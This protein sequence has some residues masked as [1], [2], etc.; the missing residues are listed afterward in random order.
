ME[1]IVLNCNQKEFFSD[2]EKNHFYSFYAALNTK[3]YTQTGERVNQQLSTTPHDAMYDMISS[4]LFIVFGID[5]STVMQKRN[6]NNSST[7]NNSSS[8]DHPHNKNTSF[9]LESYYM[10]H[11]EVFVTSRKDRALR[12]SQSMTSLGTA[13]RRS[14][15][16]RAHGSMSEEGGISKQRPVLQLES[17]SLSDVLIA[18][19][20]LY[21]IVRRIDVYHKTADQKHHLHDDTNAQ[22]LEEVM[23]R[24]ILSY[25]HN[26]SSGHHHHHAHAPQEAQ[27]RRRTLVAKQPLSHFVFESLKARQ[28]QEE[29]ADGGSRESPQLALNEEHV[30]AIRDQ[31]RAALSCVRENSYAAPPPTSATH[32][33]KHAS[34]AS[35]RHAHK[36]APTPQH[37][38]YS[39][40]LVELLF[41]RHTV[42][43]NESSPLL[44]LS[45]PALLAR[46]R[47]ENY[48]YYTMQRDERDAA[49]K[50]AQRS[51]ARSRCGSGIHPSSNAPMFE[52]SSHSNKWLSYGEDILPLLLSASLQHANPQDSENSSNQKGRSRILKEIE[53]INEIENTNLAYTNRHRSSGGSSFAI[54]QSIEKLKVNSISC[55]V[56]KKNQFVII[57]N[58]NGG[59]SIWAPYTAAKIISFNNYNSY[60]LLYQQFHYMSGAANA[61][62]AAAATNA[63]EA[64]TD[65]AQDDAGVRNTTETNKKNRKKINSNEISLFFHQILKIGETI[66]KKYLTCYLKHKENAKRKYVES[67]GSKPAAA[68]R[69][70]AADAAAPAAKDGGSSFAHRMS[71]II[72]AD[73][74]KNYEDEKAF[75]LLQKAY[76]QEVEGEEGAAPGTSSQGE[77]PGSRRKDAAG[78]RAVEDDVTDDRNA[79]LLPHTSAYHYYYYMRACERLTDDRSSL[80][81]AASPETIFALRR[82]FAHVAAVVDYYRETYQTDRRPDGAAGSCCEAYFDSINASNTCA[83]GG[84]G[85]TSGDGDSFVLEDYFF[86]LFNRHELS[87]VEECVPDVYFTAV[88]VA[89][90]ALLHRLL[91]FFN[92]GDVAAAG[93]GSTTGASGG[94]P[95]AIL[96]EFEPLLR[97]Q[98]ATGSPSRHAP[99][100]ANRRLLFNYKNYHLVAR[101]TTY[102]YHQLDGGEVRRAVREAGAQAAAEDQQRQKR[103]EAL[104]RLR[105]LSNRS[106]VEGVELNT[107][108]EDPKDESVASL[109]STDFSDAM[110]LLMQPRKGHDRAL[111]RLQL[112]QQCSVG[113]NDEQFFYIAYFYHFRNYR[114]WLPATV[115]RDADGAGSPRGLVGAAETLLPPA[116][117]VS[118]RSS[119]ACGLNYTVH[120]F[121]GFNSR[122]EEKANTNILNAIFNLA[123]TTTVASSNNSSSGNPDKHVDRI[124]APLTPSMNL[125]PTTLSSTYNNS[126]TSTANTHAYNVSALNS[127]DPTAINPWLLQFTML[128]PHFAYR[129]TAQS[130]VHKVEPGAASM[131]LPANEGIW[132]GP[133]AKPTTTQTPPPRAETA[134]PEAVDALAASNTGKNAAT[135]SPLLSTSSLSLAFVLTTTA[136]NNA[137]NALMNC[138]SASAVTPNASPPPMLALNTA[139]TAA[140][141]LHASRRNSDTNV[142]Y[143]TEPALAASPCYSEVGTH[144][145]EDVAKREDGNGSLPSSS[146]SSG[147]VALFNETLNNANTIYHMDRAGRSSSHITDSHSTM[148][149]NADLRTN[150]TE[151][152]LFLLSGQP[153]RK[154]FALRGTGTLPRP[155]PESPSPPPA[156]GRGAAHT[157]T[158]PR[159]RAVSASK[160]LF[161]PMHPTTS[162]TRLSGILNGSQRRAMSSTA[163]L[164]LAPTTAGGGSGVRPSSSRA[165][166]FGPSIGSR[167]ATASVR[168]S[169]AATTVAAPASLARRQEEQLVRLL[170][171]DRQV[172]QESGMSAV[173]GLGSKPGSGRPLDR[174]R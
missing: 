69:V 129:L 155:R 33:G 158:L 118:K 135:T 25:Q 50:E 169:V 173:P 127:L 14:L 156:A 140:T 115:K 124:P 99:P 93:G 55:N 29:D 36:S 35:L 144:V 174:T 153:K 162:S 40:Y 123:A 103:A 147:G 121:C 63:G 101:M 102:Y 8:K 68:T 122:Y 21:D 117:R 1:P 95:S 62:D 163:P 77:R 119:S 67:G 7:N 32:K 49:A 42:Y 38:V 78:A 141:P 120:H 130:Y 44:L 132:T 161:P 142:F 18:F 26:M 137:S 160:S 41:K 79:H 105:S 30:Q 19:S 34:S 82:Y 58:E 145:T 166:A 60:A 97:Q 157:P 139:A 11:K 110:W 171:A 6:N 104:K 112:T 113:L 83:L 56:N 17:F 165:Y 172:Q 96:S 150:F 152:E 126:T 12:N 23:L 46:A 20:I 27:R 57:G 37:S 48:Y 13:H 91:Y 31:I 138:A 149:H 88:D 73:F 89:L 107:T 4:F 22:S 109:E 74:L 98:E 53:I 92:S 136:N 80:S 2:A 10:N 15:T 86:I 39:F 5:N 85:A 75:D 106:E 168:R 61:D 54:R 16:S 167:T 51:A 143:V 131:A 52:A 146:S 84:S 24:S 59:C 170:Q 154:P 9:S 159:G 114:L 65:E 45:P 133:P 111:L 43:I 70:S 125:L 128:Y 28:P 87:R 76:Q 94:V 148:H 108:N 116:R 64:V 71:N 66:K 81:E 134:E 47:L 72:E 151:A 3:R 164:P 90:S 100:T